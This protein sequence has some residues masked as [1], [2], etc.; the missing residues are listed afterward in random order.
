MSRAVVSRRYVPAALAVCCAA[1]VALVLAVAPALALNTHVFSAS[2]GSS[3]EGAGMLSSP[4]GVAVDAAT[5]DVYVADTG[6]LRVDEFSSSG[7]FVRAWGWEVGG[8]P[9]FGECTTLTSC[10]KGASG[11]G[12]GEFTT[13]VFVAVDNSTTSASKGDVYVGDT[14]DNVVSKFSEAGVLLESWGT[15][16]QLNGSTATAGSF[17]EVA[18]IAVDG[19]G[20]LDVISAGSQLFR[21]AQTGAFGEE[22][23]VARGTSKNG[24][25]VDAAGDLFKANGAPNVDEFTGSGAVLGQV[26][27][28]A[29]ATGLAVDQSTGD[30]YVGEGGHVEHYAFPGAGEVSERSGTPCAFPPEP[31]SAGCPASD[32]FGSGAL[33]A[34]GGVAFDA[35]S[36]YVADA[37]SGRVDVFAAA[38][39]P[40]VSTLP[41]TAVTET[42]ASLH[43]T[44]NPD[45][46][47]V[48]ACQFEY[49]AEPGVY[50]HTVACSPPPGS[51]STPVAVSAELTGLTQNTTYHYRLAASNATDKG[52]SGEGQ[53]ESFTTPGPPTIATQSFSGVGSTHAMLGAQIDPDGFATH[54]HFEYDTSA[55]TTSASHGTSIPIPDGEIPA[56]FSEQS[57]S[58]SVTGL[59]PS[60]VYHFRL[61]ASNAGGPPVD[62]TDQTFTTQPPLLIDSESASD[63]VATS[64]TLEAQINP[65]GT[66]TTCEFSYVTDAAF[67]STGY[68]TAVAAPCPA[69]LGE[70]ETDVP[71]S[72]HV[73]GLAPDTTY[74]YRVIATNAVTNAGGTQGV[75]HVFTTQTAG[76]ALVL[77]D[78]RS[79]E[80]VSP[81]NKH[82]ALIDP[83]SIGT[84]Q[85]SADGSAVTYLANAP[86]E[87]S[88]EGNTSPEP[89][90]VLA[91]R[92]PG[93]W[94]SQDIA[95]PH[96]STAVPA[97]APEYKLFSPDLSLALVEPLE[98]TPLAPGASGAMLY[99]RDN[100][101]G[102]YQALTRIGVLNQGKTLLAASP[103]LHYVVYKEDGELYEWSAGHAELV[104]VLPPGTPPTVSG[105]DLG[106][107]SLEVRHAVSDDGSRVIFSA[108][109]NSNQSTSGLFV[110][111]V[112]TGVTVRANPGLPGG[113]GQVAG[114]FQTASNDGGKIFFTSNPNVSSEVHELY[115][116]DLESGK[117]TDL[118]LGANLDGSVLGAS[119]D[120]S[121]VYFVS[122]GV[123][124]DAAQ[125]GAAPGDCFVAATV[126]NSP[127]PGATCSLYVAHDNGTEWQTTF[128]ATLSGE[129]YPDWGKDEESQLGQFTSRVSP[130]GR[131][132]AFMSDRSLTGYDNHDVNSGA[133]D[134]E[135]FLYD[136]STHRLACASCDPTGARP[137]GLFD[138]NITHQENGGP[139]VDRRSIW[140]ERWL[141][142]NVPGWEKQGELGGEAFSQPRY[143]LDSGRLF[144][145][146]SDALVPHDTNG[147]ED[148]YQYEPSGEGSC[149][150]ENGCVALLSS[151]R[152]GEESAFLDASASGD[153][154]FL[155]TSAQ[156][157]PQDF[158]T[159]VDVYDAHV[160]TSPAPCLSAASSPP[161]CTTADACRAAPSPQP[162]IFGEPSSATFSGAGN[163]APT[164]TTLA[165]GKTTKK[166]VKCS[167]GKRLSRGR[168]MKQAS[169]SRKGGKRAR[170]SSDERRT[171]R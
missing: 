95:T 55:Y 53:E 34:T 30:L 41:S 8:L 35:G 127:P 10:K 154:A 24:L 169:R 43:G 51:G 70:G 66:S 170:R 140:N 63:V 27:A 156:L 22:F 26:T 164:A 115:V 168:C 56:G 122:D 130:N 75:D 136:A 94:L 162:L 46:I 28:S 166:T 12:P 123:L 59:K 45:G 161:A 113:P 121:S 165:P 21:F 48:S 93:G 89:D 132:V 106:A 144:F 112:A 98:P 1:L 110:R 135:V 29:E 9:G 92:L 83:F 2:F 37:T 31:E 36:V 171:T 62:G 167:K 153:D 117:V 157:V 61:V 80:L 125:H 150:G 6:N 76:E 68:E 14:G 33:S 91:R 100:T 32:A 145:N 57:V 151:G 84:S 58:A 74:H 77:P 78:G 118:S 149:A 3:G 15:K 105:F 85:A 20:A 25:A 39:L 163:L 71:T 5:L 17:G 158:D 73:Q 86:T 101:N 50:P 67:H 7:M 42:T 147:R 64:A 155:L 87:A 129:D 40:D 146:S 124:G 54:Y 88:P 52:T 120:G 152:S 141:A 109:F 19:A 114:G 72:V 108:G 119:E 44:V 131:Y 49:G 4:G 143:L 103:D 81:P 133:R 99:L 38:T 90:Q 96:S 82:G 107:S 18:G 104:S 97:F 160:C 142:G 148:V 139:L 16:G 11:S 79:W 60:T 69:V 65:L 102:T 47:A 134:E 111:N 137:A 126:N 159:A 23:T 116:F 13:P 138:T 128:I